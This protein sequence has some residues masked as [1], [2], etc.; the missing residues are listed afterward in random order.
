MDGVI[1][2]L[3]DPHKSVTA[4]PQNSLPAG[5][6][7]PTLLTPGAGA[8]CSSGWALPRP[9]ALLQLLAVGF[10]LP[11]DQGR[12]WGCGAGPACRPGP[13]LGSLTLMVVLSL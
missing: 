11:Q 4:Q 1:L 3:K 8:D 7:R 5:F 6:R 13:G 9:L 2:A 10:F 12:R